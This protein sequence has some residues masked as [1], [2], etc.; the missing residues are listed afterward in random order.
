MRHR[1]VACNFCTMRFDV[2]DPIEGAG[3][4]IHGEGKAHMALSDYIVDGWQIVTF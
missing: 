4:P 3:I 1:A 2:R